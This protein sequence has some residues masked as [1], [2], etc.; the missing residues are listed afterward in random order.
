[1]SDP[2]ND[3]KPRGKP[4]DLQDLA[5]LNQE[6]AALV[7][8]GVPLESSL[9]M[10]AQA[11][12]SRRWMKS[13]RLGEEGFAPPEKVGYGAQEVLM[14]RLAQ[15]LREGRTFADALELEGADLPRI[16]RAVV[17]AGTR[18]GRLPEALEALAGFAQS[19][20]Q[21]RRRIDL[22]L[23]YPA[24]VLLLASFLFAGVI[25]FFVPSLNGAFY[26]LELP[27]T[28]WLKRLE[29]LR[30]RLWFWAWIMPAIVVGLGGWWCTST[31]GRFG[32]K[33]TTDVT[34]WSAFNAIPGLRSIVANFRRA[35]FCDLLAMLLEHQVS[36]P[37]ASLLAADAAGDMQL[38]R[39]AAR[40]ADGVR[41]GHSLADCLVVGRE[42]PPFLSWMLISGERQGNLVAT[43]RQVA[44]VLR[45][46]AGSQ[47][48]WLR[49]VLPSAL[50]VIIGG[51]AVLG[52]A[53]TVFGPMSQLLGRL[54]GFNP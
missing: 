10:L 25:S 48:D 6:I 50:V 2:Q 39:V 53:V 15:R 52:Y 20:L 9:S 4:I 14:L 17:I 42:L 3:K 41:S 35:N 43:L 27:E 49:V 32:L 47:S 37:E 1:M 33:G 54:G 46:R 24:L 36:L 11:D 22:A 5:L 51:G 38:Q 7:R 34:A 13:Y 31:R 12:D 21:L 19:T 30:E 23:L 8:A 28:A 26:W 40:I 16:Y 18:T 45:Q 44:T 29:W